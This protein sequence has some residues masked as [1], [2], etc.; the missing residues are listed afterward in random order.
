METIQSISHLEDLLDH[1]AEI[2]AG[3]CGQID[4][5]GPGPQFLPQRRI[6]EF[7]GQTSETGR[8]AHPQ[9]IAEL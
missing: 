5:L 1:F 6:R 9:R 8:T 3:Q 2:G 7:V 4:R